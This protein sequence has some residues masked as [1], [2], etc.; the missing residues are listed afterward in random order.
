MAERA[1]GMQP[2]YGVVIHDAC[3]DPKTSVDHLKQL[4]DQARRQ[5]QEQGDLHGAL[6]KL[7]AE[8]GRRAHK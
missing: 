3:K 2:L 1:G 6:Q 5:L 8:I 7:E 4:R